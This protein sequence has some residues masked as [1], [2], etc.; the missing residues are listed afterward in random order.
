MNTQYLAAQIV[1]DIQLVQGSPSSV[2][3]LKLTSGKWQEW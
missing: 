2:D 3:Q 1:S